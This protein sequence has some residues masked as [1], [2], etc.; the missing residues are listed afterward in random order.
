MSSSTNRLR[1]R[2]PASWGR[3]D[4]SD[5]AKSLATA[6]SEPGLIFATITPRLTATVASFIDGPG[7]VVHPG[8]ALLQGEDRRH[9]E[10]AEALLRGGGEHRVRA[11]GDRQR[12]AEPVA[13]VE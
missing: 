13:L 5:S 12:H 9:V 11:L 8:Q 3:S 7:V 6:S 2:T 4:S 10:V 1:W